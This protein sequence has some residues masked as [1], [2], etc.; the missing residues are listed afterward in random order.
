[1]VKPLYPSRR[2]E[3]VT[4][5]N[6]RAVKVWLCP[7]CLRPFARPVNLCRHLTGTHK[8]PAQEVATHMNDL[9]SVPARK[10]TVLTFADPRKQPA[11][12]TQAPHAGAAAS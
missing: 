2:V 8:L 4:V 10:T 5:T 6:D 11:R 9:V 1:M 7:A 12:R 3:T